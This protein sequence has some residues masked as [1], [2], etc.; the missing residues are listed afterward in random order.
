MARNYNLHWQALTSV[1][2]SNE[3]VDL[4]IHDRQ[5]LI[6]QISWLGQKVGREEEVKKLEKD[7][8]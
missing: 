8:K 3:V 6:K 5:D 4:M 2:K 7:Y 1:K